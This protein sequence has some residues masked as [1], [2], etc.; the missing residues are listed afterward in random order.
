MVVLEERRE[1]RAEREAMS[2]W[3]AEREA[4][5]AVRWPWRPWREDSFSA[6]QRMRWA[7]RVEASWWRRASFSGLGG[8]G[9]A[10][11]EEEE[12][13]VRVRGSSIR[14]GG[15]GGFGFGW[16]WTGGA[17]GIC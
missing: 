10:G 16:T 9:G 7:W 15:G 14:S 11:S 5:I 17:G 1:E 2:D 8:I 3:R 13:I 6:R 12:G 4:S